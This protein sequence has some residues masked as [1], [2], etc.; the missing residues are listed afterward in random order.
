M[1]Q[2]SKIMKF[3]KHI[4]E[5]RL[6]FCQRIKNFDITNQK[7]I[8]KNNDINGNTIKPVKISKNGEIV[9]NYKTFDCEKVEKSNKKFEKKTSRTDLVSCLDELEERDDDFDLWTISS[10]KSRFQKFWFYFT[11]PIRIVLYF[12]IP[13]PVKYRRFF[14]F[15]FIMCIVWI[16]CISYMVFWMVIL[17]GDAF[18]IPG[19]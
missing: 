18:H 2:N 17:I 15:S 12:T 4:I 7:P 16:G 6:N 19:K 1:F 10:E 13:N 3:V 5:D 8:E 11:F 9:E 14:V